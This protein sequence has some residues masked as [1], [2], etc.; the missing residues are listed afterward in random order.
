[1]NIHRVNSWNVLRPV[2]TAKNAEPHIFVLD[3]LRSHVVDAYV[4]NKPAATHVSLP[5]LLNV[6]DF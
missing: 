5:K 6:E 4:T 3:W 1:M 2:Q